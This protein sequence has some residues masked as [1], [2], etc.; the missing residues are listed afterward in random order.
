MRI[1]LPTLVS[2]FYAA[3]IKHVLSCLDWNSTQRN[4]LYFRS[5]WLKKKFGEEQKSG[6]STGLSK[7]DKKFGEE[8]KDSKTLKSQKS[9]GGAEM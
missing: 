7:A 1:S 6:K 9:T 2:H 4:I 8:Q 5:I 3:L